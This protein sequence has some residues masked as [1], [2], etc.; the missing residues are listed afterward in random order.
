MNTR[1]RTRLS[2]SFA[3]LTPLMALGCASDDDAAADADADAGS[4]ATLDTLAAA[5][6]SILCAK[7]FEC[8]PGGTDDGMPADPEAEGFDL[9]FK[10]E[11]SCKSVL[12]Q[13]IRTE[14]AFDGKENDFVEVDGARVRLAGQETVDAEFARRCET[15][16]RAASEASAC[17]Q[18][19]REGAP[20]QWDDRV[21]EWATGGPVGEGGSC[22]VY[23]GADDMIGEHS[24]SVC[25]AGLSC[26]DGLCRAPQAE[27]AACDAND[28]CVEG[29]ICNDAGLCATPPA[30]RALGESCTSQ[31]ECGQNECNDGVCEANGY[32]GPECAP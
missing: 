30:L 17:D 5:E 13:I 31:V 6:A 11:A 20:L 12:G 26:F 7:T 15:Q 19:S 29:L 23:F 4:E 16:M 32:G 22:T 21:C 27:G 2:L 18:V 24:D 8:C 3:L 14:I 28:H 1:T 10:D 25:R 9:E